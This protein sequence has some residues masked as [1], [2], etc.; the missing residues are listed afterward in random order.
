MKG[1]FPELYFIRKQV[2]KFSDDVEYTY[3]PLV[4]RE[5]ETLSI[6]GKNVEKL[7]GCKITT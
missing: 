1:K 4:F 2:V 6:T 5:I 3:K 7:N